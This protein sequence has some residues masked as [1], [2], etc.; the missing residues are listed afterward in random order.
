MTH[1][2]PK[3]EKELEILAKREALRGY[4]VASV[5]LTLIIGLCALAV[6]GLG[7]SID[8]EFGIYKNHNGIEHTRAN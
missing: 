4:V 3:T 6:P 7:K 1:Y 8:Q 2:Q 5:V